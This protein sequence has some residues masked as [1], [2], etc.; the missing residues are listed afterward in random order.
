MEARWDLPEFHELMQLRLVEPAQYRLPRGFDLEFA[1]ATTPEER[2]IKEL[3]DQYRKDQ[4]TKL[5]TEIFGQRKRRAE[6]ERKLA[7]K[8]TKAPAE[9][10]RIAGT[11]VK[12]AMGKLAVQTDDKPHNPAQ[13]AGLSLTALHFGARDSNP[14]P[15]HYECRALN[16]SS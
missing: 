15:R 8:E 3:S 9:S 1:D 10:Q 4:V 11:K 16:L 7:V 6:A 13:L 2:T 14:R 5:E 12:Q